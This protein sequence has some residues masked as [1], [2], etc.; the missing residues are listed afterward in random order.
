MKNLQINGETLNYTTAGDPAAPLLL[1]VHG[2]GSFHGVWAGTMAAL[3]ESYYC[4]AL[5]LLGFGYSDKPPHADY[6]IP[7]QAGRVLAL[8]ESLGHERF[9]VM[10]HSMGGQIA[11]YLAA[12]LAGQRV[13]KL[14]D[15]AGVVAKPLTGYMENVISTAAFVGWLLPPTYALARR[16]VHNR[17]Y[18]R[19]QFS[20]WFHRLNAL[21]FDAW[22]LDRQMTVQDG[23]ES[24]V[25]RAWQAIQ[26]CDLTPHLPNIIAPTL[27]IFGRQDRAVQVAQGE[28]AAKYIPHSQLKLIENC[29]HFPMYEQPSAFLGAVESFLQGR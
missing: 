22:A 2:W 26:N 4:V 5:D 9:S 24:S 3:A 25:Y 19:V 28:T 18:A 20:T 10:G 7:A 8:A 27:V 29:G 6:S 21:P 12:C 16:M 1:M 13:E 15:V 11:M 17:L 14:V 23:M